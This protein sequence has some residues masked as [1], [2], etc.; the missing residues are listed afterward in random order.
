MGNMLLDM[1]GLLTRKK[2]TKTGEDQDF[3]VLGKTPK[4]DVDMM[5]TAPKMHNEL[6]RLK[7]LKAY[8][9]VGE[10]SGS[11]SERTI[12]IDQRKK[13]SLFSSYN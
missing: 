13:I 10:I 3:L 9:D 1:M 8:F 2:V 12:P 6:I 5:F 4:L 11:G 7:D